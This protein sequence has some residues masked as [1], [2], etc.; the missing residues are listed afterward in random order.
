METLKLREFFSRIGYD[1][2]KDKVKLAE[3]LRL[4]KTRVNPVKANSV[5]FFF[6]YGMEQTFLIKAIAD[7]F[8]CKNFY[9]IGTGRG[10]ASYALSLCETIENIVTVDIIPFDEPMMT[11]IGYES[12]YASNANLNYLVPY[13]EK[14]KI[15]FKHVNDTIEKNDFDIAFIDGSHTDIQQIFS[16]YKNVK[17]RLTDDGI[18]IWD[19]YDPNQFVVKA[20]VDDII[21]EI[22]E[23]N[24]LLIEFRGHLF[25]EREPEKDSGIMLM[26]KKALL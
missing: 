1:W 3:I 22:P 4:T 11:A 15:E 2:E 21:N 23:Y 8:R 7:H 20:V 14:S 17:D 5:E 19:D 26:S 13:K 16:D 9:E 10:T 24:T 12:A 18:I 6:S 25:D